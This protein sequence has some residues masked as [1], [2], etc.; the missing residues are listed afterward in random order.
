MTTQKIAWIDLDSPR[1]ELSNGG[2]AIVVSS[3]SGL[4]EN[5]FFVCVSLIGNPAVL[6]LICY[7]V[8]L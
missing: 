8:L 1:R 2:L 4:L 5:Q 3:P 7:A 6:A